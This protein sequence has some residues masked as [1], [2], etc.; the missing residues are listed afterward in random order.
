VN[1]KKTTQRVAQASL[2]PQTARGGSPAGDDEL[3]RA[4]RMV[5]DQTL[6]ENIPDAMLDLLKKLG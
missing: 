6:D 4:L 2:D 5:Y 3:A 1:A